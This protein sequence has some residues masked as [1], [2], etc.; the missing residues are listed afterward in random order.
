MPINDK[1]RKI[2]WGRSGNR[3]AEC[4]QELV[5]DAT[6][7][8]FESVVGE[9]C[10]IIS[11]RP[12]GPRQDPSYPR[13]E[14]DSLEN[15]LLLCRIHHKMVDDQQET[16]TVEIL[17]RMKVNHE[18]WVNQKLS[19]KN[20]TPRPVKIRRIKQN[21]PTAL[22][23]LMSGKEIIGLIADG[24]SL[25]TGNDELR[26]QEE[27][28]LVGA[29]FQDVHD[30]GDIWDDV[31]PSHKVST[32]YQLTKAIQ[33]LEEAGFF[34]FGAKEIQKLEGGSFEDG[35][36]WVLVTLRVVRKGSAEIVTTGGQGA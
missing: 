21:I 36:N 5:L 10:H 7:E 29:F 26:S 11:A 1:V 4:K 28:D 25:I 32:E 15:V 9:E 19:E 13:G 12:N 20:Q 34:V 33:G 23:R 35:A 17:R 31:E 2:L 8:S 14:L 16:Y 6:Q 24:H 18:I 3:C 30:W 22:L 27:V